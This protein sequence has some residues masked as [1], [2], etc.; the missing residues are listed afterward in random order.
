MFNTPI[1]GNSEL[2]A[3]LAQLALET[4]ANN[5]VLVDSN[6]GKIYDGNTGNILY[7][8][9]QYIQ[10]KYA[11]DNIGTNLSNSPTNKLFFGINNSASTTESTNPAD[12]TWYLASG[13]F[14]TNKFLYYLVNGG[15]QITFA[16]ATSAPSSS[17]VVD[18]GS[19]ID[20]D[21]VTASTANAAA[22][23]A[24]PAAP[25]SLRCAPPFTANACTPPLVAVK[26][27][28]VMSILVLF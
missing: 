18:S 15:R 1:T 24:H 6:T 23:A 20:L 3:Y 22:A 25:P 19:A 8:L 14:S 13:G 2:D 17:Y 27:K 21:V 9:Y 7:Y 10:V 5:G 12:Y 4:D 16:V 28:R 11:D 26:R